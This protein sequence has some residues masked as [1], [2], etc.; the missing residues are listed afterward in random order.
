M[1]GNGLWSAARTKLECTKYENSEVD[2]WTNNIRLGVIVFKRKL[3][4]NHR[5]QDVKKIK[6]SGMSCDREVS[7]KF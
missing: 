7:A 5:I 4:L 3:G 1:L 6:V 2:D